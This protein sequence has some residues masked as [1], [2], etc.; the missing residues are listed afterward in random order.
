VAGTG[1]QWRPG[2]SSAGLALEVELSTPWDLAWYENRVVV[3]M[4]GTHQLWAFDPLAGTA[5][6]LAGTTSEGLR[7][8][9][10]ATAWMAQPSGLA[11]DGD[12]LWIADSE[13]S[14]LRRLRGGELETVVGQ[15]LFAFGHRDGPAAEALFQHPLGVAM[16]PDGSVAVCDTYN[17]AIRRYDPVVDEVTTLAVGVAEPSGAVVVN[18]QLVVVESAAHRLTRPLAAGILRMMGEARHTQRPVADLAPGPLSLEVVFEPPPGQQLDERDG[19]AT[20]LSVSASPASLLLLGEGTSTGLSREL[21]LA[22]SGEGVLH[23]S[24]TGASCDIDAEFA[25]CHVHQ[26]DW[27]I[28]VRVVAGAP[29][30]LTLMLRG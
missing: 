15:G 13:T 30:T 6:V 10:A 24:A 21:V 4:A 7:D 19:P 3:A 16:L 12:T 8:G 20:R 27:G 17:N 11:V 14:A 29:S 22:E 25:A 1:N 5:S 18:G 2:S 23:L 28:P 26:Q 9:P